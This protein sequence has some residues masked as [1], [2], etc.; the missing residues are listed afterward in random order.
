MATE[1]CIKVLAS[2]LNYVTKVF[3]H[4]DLDIE[5]NIKHNSNRSFLF[6][7]APTTTKNLYQS[8]LKR[9]LSNIS[10]SA[11]SMLGCKF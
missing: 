8:H 5:N 3:Y 4:K 10:N 1:I 11:F 9:H 7:A 6:L 2:V